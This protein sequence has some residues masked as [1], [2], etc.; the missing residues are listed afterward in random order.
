MAASPPP[1]QEASGV[2]KGKRAYKVSG[3]LLSHLWSYVAEKDLYIFTLS[4]GEIQ[5]GWLK[6]NRHLPTSRHIPVPS[7]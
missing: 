1:Y 2:I 4:D 5:H 6:N 3:R 7:L